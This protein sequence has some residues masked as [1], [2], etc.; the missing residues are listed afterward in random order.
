MFGDMLLA[1]EDLVTEDSLRWT[2][3]FCDLPKRHGKLKVLNKFDAGFFQVT[4][5]QANFMDPQVRLLLEASWEA[6]V[7][8][9]MSI[10]LS[11]I[12]YLYPSLGKGDGNRKKCAPMYRAVVVTLR[13]SCAR[14]TDPVQVGCSTFMIL[15]Y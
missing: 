3:G 10:F 8:A 15:E 2:P 14:T 9:G 5:K 4:P 12:L 13:P 11:R 7:D 1:G 6:M